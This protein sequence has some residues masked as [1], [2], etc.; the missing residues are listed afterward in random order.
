MSGLLAARDSTAAILSIGAITI[1]N[2]IGTVITTIRPWT[3]ARC[4]RSAPEEADGERNSAH[5]RIAA[6]AGGR[7]RGE[8]L[9]PGRADGARES[10]R[11]VSG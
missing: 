5:G 2:T 1:P 10:E 4:S 8:R 9:R 6:D 11:S 3:Q 7:V